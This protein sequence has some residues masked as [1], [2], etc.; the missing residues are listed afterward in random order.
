MILE[1]K[2]N[3]TI[4]IYYCIL[5]PGLAVRVICVMEPYMAKGYDRTVMMLKIICT[6]SSKV[7]HVSLS[8][9][10]KRMNE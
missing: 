6:F 3:L 10:A 1:S 4:I 9:R 2:I 7:W 8:V 5:G